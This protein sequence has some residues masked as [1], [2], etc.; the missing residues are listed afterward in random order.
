MTTEAITY[1]SLMRTACDQLLLQVEAQMSVNV[2][3]APTHGG[4]T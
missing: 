1:V 2:T 4:L 3:N